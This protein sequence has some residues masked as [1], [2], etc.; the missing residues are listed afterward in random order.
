M[1]FLFFEFRKLPISEYKFKIGKKDYNP[2][3]TLKT[4][5]NPLKTDDP[6]K[7]GTTQD[8]EHIPGYNGFIPAAKTLGVAHEQGQGKNPRTD[9]MKTFLVGNM[10]PYV[11]GYSGHIPSAPCNQRIEMRNSCFGK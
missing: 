4:S 5:N 8:T 10:N 9:F 6:L 7:Y 1:R 11:P 3:H 2:L